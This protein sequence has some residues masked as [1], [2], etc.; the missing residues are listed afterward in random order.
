MK[1]RCQKRCRSLVGRF[2]NF[3]QRC[4]T[5]N[6]ARLLCLQ[7]SLCSVNRNMILFQTFKIFLLPPHL[8]THF[9]SHGCSNYFS[10][11]L[12]GTTLNLMCSIDVLLE[13]GRGGGGIGFVR[14]PS[15]WTLF[16]FPP[17]SIPPSLLSPA[18]SCS[19]PL[20]FHAF[21]PSLPI[22]L[23]FL[24]TASLSKPVVF[25]WKNK[26]IVISLLIAL[27][28]AANKCGGSWRV[29]RRFLLKKRLNHLLISAALFPQLIN[30]WIIK[31]SILLFEVPA[32]CFNDLCLI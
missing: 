3:P 19:R 1:R 12:I 16:S 18:T 4:R 26:G 30:N 15:P 25:I 20:T 29:K 10:L 5:T 27:K 9:I 13:A 21:S 31:L 17:H 7:K 24:L 28:A 14:S 8:H 23:P 32:C 2:V 6:V 11:P 22:T